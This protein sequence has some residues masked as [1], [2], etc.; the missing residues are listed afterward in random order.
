MALGLRVGQQVLFA[1][2]VLH[3]WIGNERTALG[4][5]APAVRSQI[6]EIDRNFAN[7]P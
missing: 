1:G 4:A 5:T 7:I 3:W 2:T 6:G